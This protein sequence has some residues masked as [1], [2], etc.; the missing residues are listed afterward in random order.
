[1]KQLKMLHFTCL[2]ALVFLLLA[3]PASAEDDGLMTDVFD[4]AEEEL[5]V[6]DAENILIITD[7]G[8]PAESYVYMDDFYGEFYGNGLLYTK[9]L[10][11]VQNPRNS[12]L[13]FAFFDKNSGNCTFIEVSYGEGE[14]GIIYQVTENINFEKLSG[15]AD[16]RDEWN[17]KMDEKVF[18]GREFA[19]VTI[20]NAW[21]TGNL[22]YELMQ[23]LEI[24]NHFCPGVSSGYVLAN[25]MEKNYPLNE[26]VSYTV[27]SCP[28][29]CKEDVFVKR[30]DATPGKRG[31]WASELSDEEKEALGGAPAGIFVVSDSGNMKAVVLGFDFDPVRAECGAQEDDPFWVSKY[32]MD[33]YLMDKDNWDELVYEI[34]VI[35]IDADTLN[36][37]KQADTNPYVVL[38][39]LNPAGTVNPSKNGIPGVGQW[40]NEPKIKAKA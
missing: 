9:N 19:I 10:L 39:L 38:G 26:G 4:A 25:W 22:D 11:V 15:N 14:E 40:M 35:D 24:H 32:L 34:E 28:T 37:M 1:M 23:C 12:P 36:E 3:L 5:G 2:A 27:F 17:A 6:L 16:S 13:W 21:A 7:I 33:L 20:T 29:W 8:S 18:R 30:W 31:L